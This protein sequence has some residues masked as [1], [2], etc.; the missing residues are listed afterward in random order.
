LRLQ[1]QRDQEP[2]GQSQGGLGGAKENK[3]VCTVTAILF[4]TIGC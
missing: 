2:V 3:R 1:T 4:Q